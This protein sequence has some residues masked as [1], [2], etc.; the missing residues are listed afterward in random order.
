MIDR[1]TQRLIEKLI[2]GSISKKEGQT[3]SNKI[4]TDV[5]LKREFE[6]RK[7][8]ETIAAEEDIFQLRQKLQLVAASTSNSLVSRGHTFKKVNIR[9]YL[10]YAAALSGITLGG[11]GAL[12]LTNKTVDPTKVYLDNFQPY[13]AV[14]VVRSG[15]ELNL[16]SIFFSAM[17]S[18][19]KGDYNSAIV[20]FKKVIEID[21]NAFTVQFYLGIT[22]MEL[23]DFEKAHENLI[24]VA[25]SNSLF[26]DQALW[27][28]G[29]CYL[30]EFKVEKAK[31]IFL[32]LSNSNSPLGQK[33]T[34]LLRDLS[35]V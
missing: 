22:Y 11:W 35:N 6:L 24:T 30:G 29:L 15:G 19:Q 5:S 21:P 25:E 13:P 9:R 1:N 33:A 3:L 32:N 23:L 14:T 34:N 7:E 8:L 12:T 28:C 26:R 17:L 31:T 20:D 18:Y 2:D 10:Y 27:Y 16:D 4:E